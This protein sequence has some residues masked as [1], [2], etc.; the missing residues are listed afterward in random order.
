MFQ[1]CQGF[2]CKCYILYKNQSFDLHSK[3]NDWFLY[4]NITFAAKYLKS[5]KKLGG[6]IGTK[7]LRYCVNN[8]QSDLYIHIENS[9]LKGLV[10][11]IVWN[12]WSTLLS[13]V[14]FIVSFL[15]LW[16]TIL[17]VYHT[18]EDKMVLESESNQGYNFVTTAY[19]ANHIS[20]IQIT[21][22]FEYFKTFEFCF[23]FLFCV[24]PN[25]F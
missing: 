19:L 3:S 20:W 10:Q 6:N 17:F 18:K 12:L 15:L 16:F 21:V 8:S 13:K 11:N 22:V 24:P 5:L 14:N 4:G 9:K 2:Y 1:C 7:W 23:F 25:P